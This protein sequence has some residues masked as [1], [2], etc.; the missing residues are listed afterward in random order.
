MYLHPSCFRKYLQTLGCLSL[1]LLI[2][3]FPEFS[4]ILSSCCFSQCF[5]NLQNP[6]WLNLQM[7]CSS[8]IF[9]SL[10]EN[11][12]LIEESSVD[13]VVHSFSP[14]MANMSEISHPM[15][16]C[17]YIYLNPC[18][19]LRNSSHSQQALQLGEQVQE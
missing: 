1:Q 10:S 15:Y 11:H 12:F 2:V 14:C 7:L 17:I 4:Q 18:Y 9:F 5:P 13:N 8:D 6:V 19:Y 3:H 16:Y